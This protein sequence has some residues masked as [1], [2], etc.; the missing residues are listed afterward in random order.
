MLPLP[1]RS[2]LTVPLFPYPSLFRS[3]FLLVVG[4]AREFARAANVANI[5]HLGALVAIVIAR[6]AFGAAEAA[7]DAVDERVLLDLQLDHMVELAAPVA[8]DRIERIGLRRGS[9]I[10]VEDHRE[11]DAKPVE[12]IGRV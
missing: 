7:G 3:R 12:Q 10:A 5:L 6:T 4:A 8:E 2:T 9:R 1:P 11:V